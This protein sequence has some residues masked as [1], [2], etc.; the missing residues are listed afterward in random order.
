MEAE[1]K[2]VEIIV[3][4][5]KKP[6]DEAKISYDQVVDLA[7]PPPH[8]PTEVF[9]VQYSRGPKD[10]PSGTLVSGQSVFVKNEMVFDVDRTDRS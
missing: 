7:F 9:T 3:N 4:A 2:H 1:H 8:R 10:N 6:W 5:K